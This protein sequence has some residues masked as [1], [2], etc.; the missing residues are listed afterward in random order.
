MGDRA[1]IAAR[2]SH[3]LRR[4]WIS[5][6]QQARGT[7]A[8]R[9]PMARGRETLCRPS[10][11][12]F[13]TLRSAETLSYLTSR[14][15]HDEP[16]SWKTC[17]QL[18]IGGRPGRRTGKPRRLSSLALF[19]RRRAGPLW[20][21]KHR[22]CWAAIARSQTNV[23]AAAARL[24]LAG[25]QQCVAYVIPLLLSRARSRRRRKIN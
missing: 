10:R 14:I 15:A 3:L 9:N 21:S 23:A 20:Q 5:R 4:S 17:D 25:G 8:A 18:E 1:L 7:A 13:A 6:A 19:S 16:R 22:T 11:S 2:P 24:R 12:N